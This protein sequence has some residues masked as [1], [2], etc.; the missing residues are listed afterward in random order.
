MNIYTRKVLW[1]R[2][3]FLLAVIIVGISLWYTNI[4]V[5]KIADEERNKVSLWAEA[6][7]RRA[8]LIKY[9]GVLFDRLGAEEYKRMELWAEA[10]R[11][12]SMAE[13]DFDFYL[14]IVSSNT[15][16]PV[17]LTNDK[18]EITTWLNIDKIQHD[19]PS[20]LSVE[21]REILAHELEL[22]RAQREPIEIP[23]Y[24]NRKNYL[25]FKD[26]KLFADLKMVMDD[27]IKS[28]ISEVVLNSATVP[29]IF[30]DESKQNV[31][32]YGNLDAEKIKDTTFVR[33][34]IESMALQNSPIEIDLGNNQKNYIF[35]YNSF[36]LTQLKYYPYVQFAVI[37][38]FLL[39][40]YLLFSTSRKAEQ[41]Q[42]WVGM[43]KETAHQLGT[44]LSSL[45]AW[46]E[47][48]E[49]KNIDPILIDE[50][51]KD[52]GRL[53]TITERFSKI[54][55]VPS[56]DNVQLS[57][58]VQNTV[59]YLQARVS[60][61]VKFSFEAGNAKDIKVPLN[62]PLFEWVIENLCKN[63]VDAMDGEGSI[64]I[65]LTDV[66]QYVFVDVSDTGKGI[67]K[68][69]FKTVFQP[70]YTTKQRGWGL[71]LSLV[72]RIVEDYHKGKIFVKRSESGKGTTFRI[73]LNK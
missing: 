22:M 35:Y 60:N 50:M 37:G 52:V 30:T 53:E 64:H 9:T 38:L 2:L 16:I 34:T 46:M 11:R 18:G 58:V 31:L 73:V 43:A 68:S 29:V 13:S 17:I 45:I 42:V 61:K 33:T 57:A 65:Q 6:I 47:L 49:L 56:L 23:Y 36:L 20:K 24:M 40:A 71:G 67:P 3:L 21:E 32:D 14:K 66:T 27:I 4:L 15:T 51:K 62:V 59:N 54:G 26:S 48:L 10:T 41:N 1:K 19:N 44:P 8:A 28:F 25:Y 55:S 7:K 70:G 63:A 5:K 72:K 12:L 39:I 69:K